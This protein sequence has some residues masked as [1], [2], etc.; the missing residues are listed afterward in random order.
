MPSRWASATDRNSNS[1]GPSSEMVM[2][3][4]VVKVA[5]RTASEKLPDGM[6]AFIRATR[7]RVILWS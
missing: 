4:A 7:L 5:P 3:L 2:A 6:R 1:K